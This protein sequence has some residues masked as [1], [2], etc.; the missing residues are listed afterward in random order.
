MKVKEI[1]PSRERCA[2][3]GWHAFDYLLDAPVTKEDI[4]SLRPL[5]S[6]VYLES[7]RKPFFKIESHHFIIKGVEGDGFFR[8]ALHQDAKDEQE[9]INRF[10][11]RQTI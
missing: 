1:I 7:L 6:L 11:T 5:G 9:Y 8:V 2:E 4:L 3:S 10:I